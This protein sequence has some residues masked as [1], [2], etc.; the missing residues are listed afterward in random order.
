MTRLLQIRLLVVDD[1]LVVRMGLVALLNRQ[2]DFKVVGEAEDGAQ[3]VEK[4]REHRPDVCL[5]DIRMPKLTGMQALTAIRAEFPE[6]RVLML[7]TYDGDSDIHGALAAGASGYLLKDVEGEELVHA[8]RE[9]HGGGRYLPAEVAQRLAERGATPQLTP[10][11]IEVLELLAK[12]LSNKEIASVLNFT[13][14]TAKAHVRNILE[15]LGVEDRTSAV[16][17]ALHRGIVHL[18]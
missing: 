3:A 14:F 15:K 8:I 2:K 18:S 7:T 9:V 6:A 5:M 4:Y 12:G 10:R 16:T 11:E 17:E 13:D 1:H